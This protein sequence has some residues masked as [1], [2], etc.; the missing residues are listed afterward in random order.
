MPNKFKL[1]LRVI[2]L[3]AGPGAGKSTAACGL[4]NLMKTLNHEVEYVS[5]FAKDMTYAKDYGTLEN[6]LVVLAEQDRRLRR[7]VGHVEWVVTDS[8]LYL[9]L[10][11]M[12]PEYKEWLTPAVW[13]AYERY[14]NYNVYLDRGDRRYQTYGRN[15]TH[16]EALE[17]D[18]EIEH[19]WM[20]AGA[21]FRL[22]STELA[23]FQIYD[24]VR[25]QV[26]GV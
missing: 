20:A 7:L 26:E 9:G 14:D 23:P 5:E 17:L 4:F 16:E 6:Q 22:P 19:L 25:Q 2:N 10:A 18:K 21:D 15:Q 12:T 13:G 24:W 1:P 11:Y 8:P 3:G